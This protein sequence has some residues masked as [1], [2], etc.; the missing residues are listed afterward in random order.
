MHYL[1]IQQ[2]L[3]KN[4]L[5]VSPVLDRGIQFLED[6]SHNWQNKKYF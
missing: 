4:L 1:F 3:S 2:V 5:E 6:K